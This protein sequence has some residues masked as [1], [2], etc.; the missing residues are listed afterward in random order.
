VIEQ[1]GDVDVNYFKDG[2]VEHAGYRYRSHYDSRAVI[3]V[4]TYEL[5][6]SQGV[7]VNCMGVVLPDSALP[8]SID[9]QFDPIPIGVF[10]LNSALITEVEWLEEHGIIDLTSEQVTAIRGALAQGGNGGTQYWTHADSSLTYNMWYE[11]DGV[12]AMWG[13]NGVRSVNQLSCCVIA[14]EVSL[15]PMALEPVS[16]VEPAASMNG[17]P[18]RIVGVRMDRSGIIVQLTAPSRRAGC[19]SLVDIAGATAARFSLPAG[20]ERVQVPRSRLPKAG[21]WY[22]VRCEID[23]RREEYV[24]PLLR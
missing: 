21:G 14:V 8:D 1:F 6:F 18:A 4:G 2:D 17:T 19:V 12:H 23:G 10:D 15:P 5:A 7:Y 13:V 9:P 11:Q 20:A 22:V 24:R 16:S 3:Y